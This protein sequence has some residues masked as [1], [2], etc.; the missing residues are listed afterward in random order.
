MIDGITQH[1]D[2]YFDFFYYFSRFEF[3]LKKV[4]FKKKGS[5]KV[6]LADWSKFSKKYKK[7]Y[8]ISEEAKELISLKPKCFVYTGRGEI[9]WRDLKTRSDFPLL[10]CVV[11]YLKTVRNNLFHGGKHNPE[12]ISNPDQAERDKKLVEVGKTVLDELARLDP[13]IESIYFSSY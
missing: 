12:G 9:G 11:L 10:S 6:V 13:E 1:K 4:G 8:T 5:Y 3:A 2:I 7:K